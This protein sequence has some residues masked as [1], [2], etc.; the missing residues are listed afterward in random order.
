EE[1]VECSSGGEIGLL[2]EHVEVRSNSSLLPRRRSGRECQH[3]ERQ[4]HE[5]REFQPLH[6]SWFSSSSMG[7]GRPARHPT[8][9][10]RQL[11]A[12]P[13]LLRTPQNV[14]VAAI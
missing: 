4:Q 6:A 5:G 2:A 3:R 12:V 7:I 13:L 1:N 14:A 11:S 9:S 10:K 8:R